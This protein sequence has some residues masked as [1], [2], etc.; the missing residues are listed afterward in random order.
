[1]DLDLLA[2]LLSTPGVSGFEE[3]VSALVASLSGGEFDEF[4]NV[5]AGRGAVAFAAHMDE[6]GLLALQIEDDGRVRLR[7][8]GGL[9]DEAI[10]G[11]RVWAYGPGLDLIGVVGVEPPHFKDKGKGDELYAD[12]GFSSKEDAAAAGLRPMT[13]VAFDRAPKTAGG[14]ITSAALDDRA[15]VW[16]LLEALREGVGAT[17]IWTVQEEV[18][19]VGA[20][21]VARRIEAKQ[22]VVVDTIA[23]CNPA[24]NGPVKPGM[25]PVLRLFDNTGAYANK[26]AK[27]VAEIARRRDIPIQIGAGGGGT[28]AAAFLQA[29]LPAVA[30]GIPNKYAHSPVEMVHLNDLKYTVELIRAI[31]EELPTRL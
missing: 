18:G 2:K 3:R 14:Y 22:V 25:G 23:C 26:L 5:I 11:A 12:F 8:V 31:A 17:F 13:P 28:D 10:R 4:G 20:K 21:S 9:E 24:V 27:A 29:G 1:M 7:K 19:L 15:G 30:V 6:V 16:A